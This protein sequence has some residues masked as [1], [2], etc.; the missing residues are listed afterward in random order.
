MKIPPPLKTVRQPY[1]YFGN[2]VKEIPPAAY[3]EKRMA[4]IKNVLTPRITVDYLWIREFLRQFAWVVRA[5]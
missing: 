2:G 4:R 5:W 1:H 3:G